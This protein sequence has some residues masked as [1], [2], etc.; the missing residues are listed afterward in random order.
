MPLLHGKQRGQRGMEGALKV[1]RR[2]DLD[3]ASMWERERGRDSKWWPSIRLW[4][5]VKALQC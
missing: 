2:V 3:V 1:R 4:R 5:H